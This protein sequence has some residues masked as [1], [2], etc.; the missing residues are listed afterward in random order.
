MFTPSQLT[1]LALST[2][3]TDGKPFHWTCSQ[4]VAEKAA[5]LLCPQ[6][7]LIHYLLLVGD[8]AIAVMLHLHAVWNSCKLTGIFLL[9]QT[10]WKQGYRR[11][12]LEHTVTL[13]I[14]T[15]SRFQ[16]SSCVP[17]MWTI[18]HRSMENIH[19]HTTWEPSL[20]LW[21]LCYM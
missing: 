17:A 7:A 8:S 14:C 1:L 19:T 6:A 4:T 9:L 2:M 11:E 21:T 3:D 12:Q 10:G 16:P 18:T 15:R 13:G 20:Q 5:K